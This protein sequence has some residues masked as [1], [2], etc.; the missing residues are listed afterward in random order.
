MLR[1]CIG[2][3][4]VAAALV[5]SISIATSPAS[6]AK[7]VEC[8]GTL[9]LGNAPK[10]QV[11]VPAGA[12]CTVVD[13]TIKSLRALPGSVAVGPADE[14]RAHWRLRRQPCYRLAP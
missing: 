6:A 13:S 3:A 9:S 2:V 11:I 4:A 12:S 7:A 14:G 5:A 10:T 8:D 1:R